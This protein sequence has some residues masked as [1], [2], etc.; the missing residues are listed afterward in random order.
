MLVKPPKVVNSSPIPETLQ[1]RVSLI[2]KLAHD[3]LPY[4]T[5]FI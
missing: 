1:Y 3:K 5:Q 2:L 4:F